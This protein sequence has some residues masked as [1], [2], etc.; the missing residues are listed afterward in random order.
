MEKAKTAGVAPGAQKIS[1]AAQKPLTSADIRAALRSTYRQPEWA[2][3][4]E[5]TNAT[6]AQHTRSADAV[7]MSL[8]P[9]RGLELHGFEI[10]VSRSDW[11]RERENPKKAETIAQYCDR[12]WLAT[13]PGVVPIEELAPAWGLMEWDG[14]RW[15]VRREAAK[16]EAADINRLFLAA[17]LRRVHKTDDADLEAI[18]AVRQKALN[19]TFEDTLRRRIDLAN[20]HFV[21][22][23]AQV[24]A[25][26]RT[27]GL[28]INEYSGGDLGP[29][30]K[31]L[32]AVGAG[33]TYLGAQRVI[34]LLE[35]SAD[36]IRAALAALQ[37]E[38]PAKVAP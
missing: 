6:G 21:N 9:S 3:L 12:W 38:V 31:V 18:L 27:S 19:D 15:L 16:T 35:N 14:K 7:A 26:E 34:E 5:V 29:A 2:L 13:S 32:K 24:D 17:L 37:I 33:E 25:F 36:R 30:V 11:R 1:K 4:F 10:K 22:L 28:T 23:K 8:W 20:R